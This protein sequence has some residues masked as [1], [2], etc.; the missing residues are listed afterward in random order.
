[1]TSESASDRI[2]IR[3]TFD[4]LATECDVPLGSRVAEIAARV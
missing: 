2:S 4:A 3:A 1:M